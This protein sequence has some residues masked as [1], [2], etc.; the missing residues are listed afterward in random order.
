MYFFPVSQAISHTAPEVTLK[1]DCQV[2]CTV[3]IGDVCESLGLE[4]TNPVGQEVG[5]HSSD[6]LL[7]MENVKSIKIISLNPPKATVEVTAEEMVEGEAK[8]VTKDITVDI[9]KKIQTREGT[10]M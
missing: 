8:P 4:G 5:V 10:E 7:G 3:S 1:A 6:T 9:D 2:E